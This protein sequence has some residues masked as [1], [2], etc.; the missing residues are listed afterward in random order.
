M[1]NL[2]ILL[3]LLSVVGCTSLPNE[4]V[5][6]DPEFTPVEP[7]EPDLNVVPTGSLFQANYA[8]SLYSDIKAHRVGDIITVFLEEAT[9][10]KKNAGTSLEKKNSY[11]LAV[12]ELTFPNTSGN[13]MTISGFGGGFSQGGKFEGDSDADQSNS[14]QGSITVNV[15]RVLSNGN[16]EIRGEKWLMLNNGEEYVRIKGVIR[17]EDVNSDNS[18]SSMH[19]ANARIQY[20]GT[21]DFAN[22]QRQG[23]LTSFFNGPYWPL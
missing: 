5:K 7:L 16:L 8:N 12:D 14:L 11:D 15:T 9:S 13:T 4:E 3:T 23:W 17:S 18:V 10:A 22:T 19:V 2:I 21:G 1:K 6:N 20:G